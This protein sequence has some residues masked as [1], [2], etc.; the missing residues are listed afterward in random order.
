[1]KYFISF[2]IGQSQNGKPGFGNAVINVDE[3]IRGVEDLDRIRK[4]IQNRYKDKGVVILNYKEM[5]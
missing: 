3:K 2:F 4:I 1:M 5:I